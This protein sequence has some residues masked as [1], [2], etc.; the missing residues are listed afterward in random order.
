M[1]R[2]VAEVSSNHHTD[3]LRCMDFVDTAKQ[4]GADSVKFQAFKIKQ[5]FSPEALAARPEL[6]K[7]QA[8][9]LPIDFIKPIAIYAHSHGLNFLCTPFY[10]EAVSILNPYVESWKIASYNLLD[11]PMLQCCAETGK[12]IILSTGAA[13]LAEIQTA[14]QT[15]YKA[16]C[17]D[18][19]LLHCM[20]SYPAPIRDVNLSAIQSI[21]DNIYFE[22]KLRVGWSDHTANPG[23][24]QRAV[25]KW[26]AEMIEFHLDLDG[27]G[28]EFKMGHCWLPK[29]A[30]DMIQDAKD[31]AM[32]DGDGVKVPRGIEWEEALWRADPSDGLRPLVSERK[33]LVAKAREDKC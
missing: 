22:G 26:G 2:F 27:T 16:G 24:V 7:R 6:L 17:V 9:E 18:L 8:W 13:T 11:T 1:I 12:P 3:L 31:G 10:L 28:D 23:V 5:L 30:K 14:T 19:T 20:S 21:R 15:L 25:H 29:I 4:I 32:A 33:A